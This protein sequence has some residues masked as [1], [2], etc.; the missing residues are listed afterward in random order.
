[1]TPNPVVKKTLF[2]KLL[3]ARC[4][5][6]ASVYEEMLSNGKGPQ[7]ISVKHCQAITDT[8]A[9]TNGIHFFYFIIYHSHIFILLSLTH[10][11]CDT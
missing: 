7:T 10:D 11:D 8:V 5:G 4:I 6:C 3:S 1:V 2:S 9:L